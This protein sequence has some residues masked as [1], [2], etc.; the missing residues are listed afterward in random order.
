MLYPVT[1]H[2]KAVF[3]AVELGRCIVSRYVR[4]APYTFAV[5]RAANW[6]D[7]EK[8]ARR[9]VED[10]VGARWTI[11]IPARMTWRRWPSGRK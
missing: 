10:L 9:A 1:P 6:E 7:L 3:I 4:R 8:Q 5:Q 2:D 11:I